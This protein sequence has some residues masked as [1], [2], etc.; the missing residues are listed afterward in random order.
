VYSVA[1]IAVLSLTLL[2][3]LSGTE[4]IAGL[5]FTTYFPAIVLTALLGGFSPGVVATLLVSIIAWYPT[6][7]DE[8]GAQAGVWFMLMVLVTAVNILVVA[9]LSATV[10]VTVDRRRQQEPAE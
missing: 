4:L 8:L 9:L 7:P 6:F 5:P 2:R 3:L 10:E 1:I